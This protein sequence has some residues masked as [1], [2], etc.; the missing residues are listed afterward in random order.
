[1]SVRELPAT[2]LLLDPLKPAS[3]V[4]TDPFPQAM[5]QINILSQHNPRLDARSN[6]RALGAI[7][8]AEFLILCLPSAWWL[9]LT[10]LFLVLILSFGLVIK[11]LNGRLQIPILTWVLI[12]PLG[13]HYVAFP[14]EQAIV[15]LDRLYVALLAVTACFVQQ[16]HLVRIPPTLRKSA[17]F[18]SIYLC[19]AGISVLRIKTPLSSF[20]V[21]WDYLLLPGIVAWFVLRYFDVR[22]RLQALHTCVCLMSIYVAAIGVAEVIWQQDL[23]PVTGGGL[24]FAGDYETSGSQILIRPN[25][26][27]SSDNSLALIALLSFFFLLFLKEAQKQPLSL[28]QTMLHRTA[29]TAALVATSLPLFRSVFISLAMAL[30][31]DAFYKPGK[32][33]LTRFFLIGMLIFAFIVVKVALPEIFE[34]RTDSGHFYGRIAEYAQSAKLFID[35]PVFG[36][37]LNN[38]GEAAQNSK[39][40]TSYQGNESV[41]SPHSNLG[42]VLAENGLLGFLPFIASQVFLVGAFWKL[43][44]RFDNSDQV[45]KT[46]VLIY[47]SYWINGSTLTLLYTGDLNIWYM[48]VLAVL[49][50]FGITRQD[51]QLSVSHATRPDGVSPLGVAPQCQKA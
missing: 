29:V 4:A 7:L 28:W 6:L 46:F 44:G 38:F 41:D 11:V 18:W 26:P 42:A 33:R 23:L 10:A 24:Y 36:V 39:Y 50:K 16:A 27:F 3:R 13:Y 45:W 2:I 35:N 47:M 32:A 8:A 5:S 49:Y 15:T 21:L 14:K 9:T 34:E 17:L 40:T 19:V 31:I 1:V 25:G 43:R 30:V 37:G 12:F 51:S 20:H 48:F 22:R